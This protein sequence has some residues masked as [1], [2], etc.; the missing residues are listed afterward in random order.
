MISRQYAW[1]DDGSIQYIRDVTKEYRSS[2]HF[3]CQ[4]CK[5]RMVAVIDV[6]KKIPHFRHYEQNCSEET[7]LHKAGKDL[8]LALFENNQKKNLP[9]SINFKQTF[10][11][12]LEQC[13]YG[14]KE[15]C[16][17]QQ[18]TTEFDLLSKFNSIM[19]EKQDSETGL[20]PDI[21]LTND[22]GEKCY[23]EIV[24]K[25]KSTEEKILSG[26]PI[27]EIYIE[28]E[29]DLDGLRSG[30]AYPITLSLNRLKYNIFNIKNNVF[31]EAPYCY[32]RLV[33]A[34]E[35]FK[36]FYEYFVATK[37]RIYNAGGKN[38]T[39]DFPEIFFGRD[40]SKNNLYLK[41]CD[42]YCIKVSF[43]IEF[44]NKDQQ[45]EYSTILFAVGLEGKFPW[46]YHY[47]ILE[48]DE[49]GKLVFQ[50]KY[51]IGKYAKLINFN[52]PKYVTPSNNQNEEDF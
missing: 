11:C 48:S 20:I 38:L 17:R 2:H 36:T 29:K 3:T 23:V 35:N 49:N 46:E 12:C 26:I 47:E 40:R 21:L 50:K 22:K 25:H 51:D 24:V 7:Y 52:K 19:L 8:F 1:S 31:R 18:R 27:I 42:G 28:K 30:D 41:S 43:T 33:T 16:I 34:R 14:R 39:R 4:S 6:K 45:D 5:S 32:A 37:G 15:L 13:R 44:S 10:K 9:L